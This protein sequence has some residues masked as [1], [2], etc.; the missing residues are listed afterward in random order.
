M[1]GGTR[2][3][4][5]RGALGRKRGLLSCFLQTL[6]QSLSSKSEVGNRACAKTNTSFPPQTDGHGTLSTKMGNKRTSW[7]Y[8]RWSL[9]LEDTKSVTQAKIR[10]QFHTIDNTTEVCLSKENIMKAVAVH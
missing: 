5:S 10:R 4:A 6:N 2:V 3:G 7:E 8:S 9:P 1:V